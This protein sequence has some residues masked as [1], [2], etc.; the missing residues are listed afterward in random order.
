MPRSLRGRDAETC[1]QVYAYIQGRWPPRACMDRALHRRVCARVCVWGAVYLPDTIYGTQFCSCWSFAYNGWSS[2]SQTEWREVAKLE[3]KVKGHSGCASYFKNDIQG[4]RSREPRSRLRPAHTL[5]DALGS[6][7][8]RGLE[9]RSW[10][11]I[12]S[13]VAFL[14]SHTPGANLSVH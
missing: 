5:W 14:V 10:F 3:K 7:P 1:C 9:L 13:P 6:G 2:P 12:S 4:I 11:V 8:G